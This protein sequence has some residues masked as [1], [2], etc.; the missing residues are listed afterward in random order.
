MGGP[1]PREDDAARKERHLVDAGGGDVERGR[2]GHCAA[3]R[4]RA[5]RR[6]G[7]PVGQKASHRGG[8]IEPAQD[9]R[10]VG[11]NHDVGCVRIEVVGVGH[12]DEPAPAERRVR[13]PRIVEHGLDHRVMPVGR[14]RAVRRDGD[15]PPWGERDS[16]AHF[17][18]AL[19]PLQDRQAA[20][21]GE[22]RIG[23]AAR[24]EPADDEMVQVHPRYQARPAV[25]DC[26]AI[27]VDREAVWAE[28]GRHRDRRHAPLPER[29]VQRSGG[30]RVVPGSVRRPLKLRR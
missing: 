1:D 22:G 11:L 18:L 27:R 16:G 13:D 25:D 9:G 30:A 21:G 10:S 17:V 24:R 5:K 20:R 28:R 23:R 3:V 6:V 15:S 26:A 4:T 12:L 14:L 8:P 2:P 29:R 19:A 7:A